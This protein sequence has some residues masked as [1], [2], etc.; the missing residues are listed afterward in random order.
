V[1]EGVVEEMLRTTAL[2]LAHILALH[3]VIFFVASHIVFLSPLFR[4]DVPVTIYL[5][6]SL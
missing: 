3:M 5:Y 4:F 6:D 2:D 1:L